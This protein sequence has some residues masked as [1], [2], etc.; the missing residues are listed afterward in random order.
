MVTGMALALR[1]LAASAALRMARSA[2]ARDVRLYGLVCAMLMNMPFGMSLIFARHVPTAE[3]ALIVFAVA[4]LSI[5][6]WR[7]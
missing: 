4:V 5:S 1:A 2:W 3:L 7:R 6:W